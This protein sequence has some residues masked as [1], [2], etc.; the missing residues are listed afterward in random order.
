MGH[1]TRTITSDRIRAAACAFGRA[2]HELIEALQAEC[3][4]D[5]VIVGRTA[6]VVAT[7][8]GG[9]PRLQVSRALRLR[10]PGPGTAAP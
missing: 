2:R 10:R 7:G 6:Y 3:P 9:S 8:R 5:A 1:R 4:G